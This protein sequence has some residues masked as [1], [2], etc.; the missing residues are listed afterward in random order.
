MTKYLLYNFASIDVKDHT[1]VTARSL[2]HE[3]GMDFLIENLNE[4]YES[5]TIKS[6]T[7]WSG[8]SDSDNSSVVAKMKQIVI[9]DTNDDCVDEMF[10]NIW[11]Y[12]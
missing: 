6:K 5:S 10:V 2:L 1:G 7:K 11:T 3:Q 8:I 9:Q 12:F 4:G